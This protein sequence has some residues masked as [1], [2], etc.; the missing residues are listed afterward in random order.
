MIVN[1]KKKYMMEVHGLFIENLVK[2]LVT[3]ILSASLNISMTEQMKSVTD[4][5]R[6]KHNEK[7]PPAKYLR[8]SFAKARWFLRVLFGLEGV[9]FLKLEIAAKD[10]GDKLP[11]KRT[12]V[13]SNVASLAKVSGA[14]ARKSS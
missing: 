12:K 9:C 3:Y 7:C 14:G 8:S 13:L 10:E 5:Y 4:G 1:T 11:R 6:G 2:K